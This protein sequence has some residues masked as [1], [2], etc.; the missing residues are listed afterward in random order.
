MKRESVRECVFE[1]LSEHVFC[2]QRTNAKWEDDD[3]DPFDLCVY[4]RCDNVRVI[5]L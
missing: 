4:F 2:W 3:D 5:A 1:A